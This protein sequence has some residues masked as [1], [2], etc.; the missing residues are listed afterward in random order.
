MLS[1]VRRAETG[2]EQVNSECPST[3]CTLSTAHLCPG[4]SAHPPCSEP[5]HFF[6]VWLVHNRWQLLNKISLYTLQQ[7][8]K[9]FFLTNLHHT[10]LYTPPGCVWVYR[11]YWP[12][13]APQHANSALYCNPGDTLTHWHADTLTHPAITAILLHSTHQVQSELC[14]WH[15]LTLLPPS[16]LHLRLLAD[17][18]GLH[19]PGPLHLLHLLLLHSVSPPQ[20][21]VLGQ[22]VTVAL[23]CAL[24]CLYTVHCGAVCTTVL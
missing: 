1:R 21:G 19:L 17:H 22:P 14:L 11:V 15:S 7:L 18:D 23:D 12:D 13:T 2:N 16:C 5:D 24:P 9:L 4:P 6:P 8:Y 10:V 20:E 3:Q